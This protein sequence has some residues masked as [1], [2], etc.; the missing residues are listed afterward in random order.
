[1][2]GVGDVLVDQ[3]LVPG[4]IPAL[5]EPLL[6]ERGAES[7]QHLSRAG[8]LQVVRIVDT[9][10]YFHKL[11]RYSAELAFFSVRIPVPEKII[12]SVAS[13]SSYPSNSR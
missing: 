12:S 8:A 1:V 13:G 2:R 10:V 9:E 4:H 6:P 11:P 5:R 7:L 3:E